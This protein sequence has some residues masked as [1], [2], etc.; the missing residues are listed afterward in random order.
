MEESDS[1]SLRAAIHRECTGKT[2]ERRIIEGCI[3]LSP[4]LEHRVTDHAQTK[5]KNAV[6]ERQTSMEPCR[7]LSAVRET[8]VVAR[9]AVRRK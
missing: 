9:A 8:A 4:R 7:A 2:P 3:I 6:S 5:K 1:F